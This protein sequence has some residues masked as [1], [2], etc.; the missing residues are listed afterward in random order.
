MTVLGRVVAIGIAAVVCLSCTSTAL[1]ASEDPPLAF[2]QDTTLE[3]TC[4]E[5][6]GGVE[7]EVRNETAVR[8]ALHLVPTEFSDAEGEPVEIGEVCGGLTVEVARHSLDRAAGT[9]APLRAAANKEQTFSGSLS[10]F[11][12]DGRVARR[13]VAI[14]PKPTV[15][16]LEA[17]PLVT[18]QSVERAVLEPDQGPVW[19]A[20]DIPNEDIPPVPKSK[21]GTMPTTVGALSGPN[22][23]V[24]VTY[25]GESEPLTTTTS[26]VALDLGHLDPGSYS[27][28]VD[29]LPGDEEKGYLALSLTATPW[30][31]IPVIFLA[32]GILGGV[33]LQRESGLRGPRGRLLQRIDDLEGRHKEAVAKLKGEAGDK[34]WGSFE[35]ADLSEL[36]ADL[37]QRLSRSTERTLIQIDKAVL[38]DM[39]TR[40]GKVENQ[41]ELLEALPEHARDLEAALRELASKHPQQLPPR[42]SGDSR[43]PQPSLDA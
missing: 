24:A 17:T 8:Q 31:P 16:A 22:G 38:A 19:V 26:L 9:T 41:I 15:G 21:Q 33:W 6:R 4:A 28:K 12:A 10:L 2:A 37:R 29:L 3:T 11:A 43:Q 30:W 7:L 27:G 5:L 23:T 20:V 18:S 1:A 14:S 42:K 34:P 25:S 36:E 32:L 35:I 13:E 39:E 40:I